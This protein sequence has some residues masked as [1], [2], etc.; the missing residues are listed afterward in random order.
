M[1]ELLFFFVGLFE[2]HFF[3]SDGVFFQLLQVGDVLLFF[4]LVLLVQFEGVQVVVLMLEHLH[5]LQLSLF[6]LFPQF[7]V[8]GLQ[9]SSPGVFEIFTLVL[10]VQLGSD[11]RILLAN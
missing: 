7:V 11:L 6:L 5:H 9:H 4:L 10:A 2:H 3:I 1:V 8:P